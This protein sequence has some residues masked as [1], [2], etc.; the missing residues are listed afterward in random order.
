MKCSIVIPVGPGHAT[1]AHRAGASVHQA[2]AKSIGAFSAVD[3]LFWDDTAGQGRSRARNLAVQQAITQHAEWLF[4]LD[5]DDLLAEDAFEQV[6]AYLE[7][8]DA[9]WGAIYECHP[10][11][12]ERICRPNQIMP[13]LHLEDVLR[14]D[15][16]LTL[17]TGYFVKAQVALNNPFDEQ[18]DCGE[19]FKNFLQ[20]WKSY[21]C[22][23]QEQALFFNIRGQ[24][25]T[26][27]RSAT[28][29]DWNLAVIGVFAQFCLENEVIV[30]LDFAGRRAKFQ[31]SNTLDHI[32]S[33]L[34]NETFFEAKEL[35]ETLYILPQKP[36]ILDVGSNI[37]NHAIFWSCIADASMIHCF[38]PVRSSA[39]QL[40]R[41]FELN[42]IAPSRYQIHEL[43][44]G[45]HTGSAALAHFDL[46]NQGA[47]QLQSEEG[48]AISIETL[49]RCLPAAKVDLLKID[50]EGMELEVL[51]GGRELIQLQRPLILI[52]VSNG[53]KSR[54]FAWTLQNDYRVHRVFEQVHAS[55]YLLCPR[56]FRPN[57]YPDATVAT[58][59][60]IP[61][62]TLTQEQNFCGWSP[63]EFIQELAP[64]PSILELKGNAATGWHIQDVSSVLKCSPQSSPLEALHTKVTDAHF[65]LADVLY[66]L[67]DEMLDQLW[68]NMPATQVWLHSVMDSRWNMYFG[69]DRIYRD[70]EHYIQMAN[71]HGFR[72][73]KYQRIPCKAAFEIDHQLSSETVLLI[74]SR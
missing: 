24:H 62:V 74:F 45:S 47:S 60:W 2:V 50:V 59:K 67:N 44:L 33:Y 13:I 43:G 14:N 9:I 61:K 3:V 16:F 55:N 31:L 7:H 57:F 10:D 53:N 52:E 68:A 48:G 1:V 70:A 42:E 58:R 63:S 72:L 20:L 5:A 11:G 32:Q 56:T 12:S 17:Q 69:D 41:N 38:E 28:G 26:G 64:E 36:H 6:A 34:A 18:M 54:F 15:P 46:G 66:S 51:K 22:I 25:S 29:Q 40:R 8:Y 37:G 49:D 21:R 65:L 27:P 4:F 71:T 35:I 73:I 39:A 23:K 19:D 30:D